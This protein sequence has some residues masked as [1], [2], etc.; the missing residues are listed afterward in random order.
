MSH[1]LKKLTRNIKQCGWEFFYF[2]A[3]ERQGLL[4][5][6][7][8]ILACKIIPQIVT[9][10]RSLALKAVEDQELVARLEAQWLIY[11]KQYPWP[12]DI[13]EASKQQLVDILGGHARL[14]SSIMHYRNKLGGFV[15]IQQYDEVP[16]MT[17]TLSHKLCKYTMILKGYQPRHISLSRASFKMLAAHPYISKDMAKAIIGYRRQHGG[18]L[19]LKDLEKLSGYSA[20]WM[21]KIKSYL[22][23]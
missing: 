18:A 7:I 12:I 5:I 10:Q 11:Q 14:A 13:N 9:S 2:S 19:A 6:I 8:L 1:R 4:V 21:E 15:N 22:I 23:D 3:S 20:A 17:S 16:G